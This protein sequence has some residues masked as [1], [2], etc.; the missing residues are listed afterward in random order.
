MARPN[1]DGSKTGRRLTSIDALRGAA[2]LAVVMVH[3]TGG[4][5]RTRLPLYFGSS[6]FFSGVAGLFS[7]LAS[8]G[9]T[10]VYLFFVISGFCIHLRWAKTRLSPHGADIEFLPFWKRRLR[11][12]YPPYVIALTIYVAMLL[13]TGKAEW[14]AF[15]TYDVGL[16]LMMLHNIDHRVSYSL[17]GVFWTLAIEEQLYLAYFGLIWLRTRLDWR[18][19]LAVCLGARVL[20]FVLAFAL[21]R[22]FGV[23]WPVNEAA[24]AHWFTWALGA[25]AVEAWLGQVQLPAVLRARRTFIGLLAVA[26]GLAYADR[27]ADPFGNAHRIMWLITDPIWGLGF[28]A[29]LNYAVAAERRWR[30]HLDAL[31]IIRALGGIGIFSYSLYLTHELVLGDVARAWLDLLN[32]PPLFYSDV[33][34]SV[35]IPVS[36]VFSWCFFIAFEKRF[37]NRP[38]GSA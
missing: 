24:A 1:L 16:H 35:F 15:F 25:L 32:I 34:V 36:I 5:V 14:S 3:A 4:G 37:M 11:R 9:S 28:F 12:L 18:K 20:W 10:G 8:F 31:L 38:E 13:L 33:L 17:N 26:G 6:W 2:A 23:V 22:M 19:T 21:H 30:T 29:L 27:F 7:L